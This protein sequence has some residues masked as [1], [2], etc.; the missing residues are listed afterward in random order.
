MGKPTI[1]IPSPNVSEDHQTKNA[2]ALV[3][4]GAAIIVADKD[5][6]T[7]LIATLTELINDKTKQERLSQACSAMGVRDAANKIVDEIETII[8][9]KIKNSLVK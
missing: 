8:K 4:K 3:N 7:T 6:N 2:M 5:A 9:T 1:L